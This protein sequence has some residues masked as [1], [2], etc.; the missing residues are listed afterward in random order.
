MGLAGSFAWFVGCVVGGVGFGCCLIAGVGG[1]IGFLGE[2][3]FTD[4]VI[5]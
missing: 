5:I 4:V 3:R 1:L 2:F